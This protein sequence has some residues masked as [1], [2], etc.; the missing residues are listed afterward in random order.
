[1]RQS[2]LLI[3]MFKALL[4]SAQ[5]YISIDNFS[6]S[7]LRN[8]TGDN[9]GSGSM[10]IISGGY[11]IPIY[12][13][14][15][16]RKQVKSFSA[17]AYATYADLSNDGEAS[18]M[19]PG[20]II[21]S[22]LNLTYIQPISKKW[23]VLLTGGAGVYAPADEINLKS[24]L[25]NG[26]AIFICRLNDNLSLGIGGGVTN[27]YGTPIAMPMMYLS[28]LRN[29]KFMFNIDMSNTIK[30]SA[31][32]ILWNKLKLEL[33]PMEIDGLL[34][35][36]SV[37]NKDQIYSM[38]MFQSYFSPSLRFSDE[39]SIFAKVGGNWIRGISA[40]ERSL[41]SFFDS[42]KSDGNED[43]YF[44]VSLRLSVGVRFSFYNNQ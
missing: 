39:F 5:G 3:L 43:P 37:G 30:I 29:G 16:D 7:R 35:V 33:A 17:S 36:R 22:G 38:V 40:R 2:V 24:V 4:M 34:A 10:W 41:K 14:I 44:D 28:W 8:K 21:N 15:N 13:K 42:F 27:S 12:T 6:T 25:G 32:T 20:K 18:Q 26:G 31:S 11:N 19:N 23:S 9:F 1:M